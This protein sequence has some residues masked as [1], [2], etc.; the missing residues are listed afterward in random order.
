MK[1]YGGNG[2]IA[3]LFLPQNWMEVS[4]QFH[5]PAALPLGKETPVHID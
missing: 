2:R 1:T 4:G 5:V 3:P